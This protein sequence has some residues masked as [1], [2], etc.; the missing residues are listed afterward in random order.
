MIV[1]SKNELLMLLIGLECASEMILQHARAEEWHERTF[2]SL[3]NKVADE[4]NQMV[5]DEESLIVEL[6]SEGKFYD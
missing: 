3:F 1:E 2:V 6:I 5:E 4:Y